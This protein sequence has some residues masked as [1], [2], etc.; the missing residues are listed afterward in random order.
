MIC[1]KVV[2]PTPGGP[3]KI[4]EAGRPASIILRIMPFG[5][6]RWSCPTYSSSVLGRRRSAKGFDI[7]YYLSANLGYSRGIAVACLLFFCDWVKHFQPSDIG[8]GLSGRPACRL[9]CALHRRCETGGKTI[10]WDK[11]RPL[12]RG[13]RPLSSA[14]LSPISQS[15]GQDFLSAVL[16]VLSAGP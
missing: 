11:H 12:R 8:I 1:A 15:A 3:H 7:T 9:F 2:L 16:S 10:H 5:P 4:M 13:R 6:T 14:S